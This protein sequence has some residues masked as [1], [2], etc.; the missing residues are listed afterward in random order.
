[1]VRAPLRWPNR[2]ESAARRSSSTAATTGAASSRLQPAA[3]CCQSS[4]AVSTRG[5]S[6]S[7]PLPPAWSPSP[8]RSLSRARRQVFQ[9]RQQRGRRSSTSQWRSRVSRCSQ[10][11]NSSMLSPLARGAVAVA[12]AVAARPGSQGSTR[13]SSSRSI[14]QLR[15]PLPRPPRSSASRPQWKP[16]C[17]SRGCRAA[18]STPLS[19]K[20][21]C[22]AGLSSRVS[23]AEAVSR[24]PA[25]R[26]SSSKLRLR[27]ASLCWL[28]SVRRQLRATP[29][30]S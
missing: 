22:S 4:M 3:A 19:W 7:G 17:C 1:M 10:R 14:T 28:R 2:P 9:A 15:L 23:R 12:V 13:P 6:Q 20:C 27:L 21:P 29:V 16:P 11:P 26:S 18:I 8:N 5:S 24:S 30:A 25:S